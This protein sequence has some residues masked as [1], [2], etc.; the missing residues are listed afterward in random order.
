MI[1]RL[2]EPPARL[3]APVT[4]VEEVVSLWRL[5]W[6]EDPL[7][8][9]YYPTGKYRFDAPAGEYP[10]LY[11]NQ[12]ALGAFA[13]VYGD[14]GI[15]EAGQAARRLS[16]ISARRPLRLIPLDDPHVL[17]RLGLD[18]RINVSKE[19]DRTQRWGLALYR[20]VPAADGI[21]YVSRHAVRHL[22]YCLFLDRCGPDLSVNVLGAIEDLRRIVLFAADG[23][24]LVVRVGWRS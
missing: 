9:R 6:E 11:G 7:H 12:D 3:L 4:P 5:H 15:I 10:T 14:V 21:R 23:Y 24:Q 18:A 2:P 16:V 22:N 17:R 1:E 13:E 20:G 19:Y 8:P